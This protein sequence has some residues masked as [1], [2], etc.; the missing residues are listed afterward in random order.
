MAA[1]FSNLLFDRN[2]LAGG[3]P[4]R[5]PAGNYFPSVTEF[6]AAFTNP[7]AEDYSLIPGTIF[8]ASGSS[9]GAIG[10]D[11]GRVRA[12]TLGTFLP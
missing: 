8:T 1:Y 5:Y 3:S 4:A 10:A 12:A 7:A 9:G 2:V 11:I 6:L